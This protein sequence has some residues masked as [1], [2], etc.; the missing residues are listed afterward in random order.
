M[1]KVCNNC[2]WWYKSACNCKEFIN[3]INIKDNDTRYITYVEDGYFSENVKEN[4]N[5][6]ELGENFIK[7][8]QEQEYI[9]KNKDIKKI[10]FESEE[11]E[12]FEYI[13]NILSKSIQNYF[14]GGI[15]SDIQ[16]KNS[17]TF[18]CCYWV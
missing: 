18:S 12:I 8:M 3:A 2:K 4:I 16:I 15:E 6:K 14:E 9:K 13:E 7:L 5:I 17:D 10:N 1:D 11:M